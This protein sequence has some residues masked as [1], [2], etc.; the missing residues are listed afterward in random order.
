MRGEQL[1]RN[2]GGSFYL[3]ELMFLA[4]MFNFQKVKIC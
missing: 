1:Y 2:A 4:T 3:L